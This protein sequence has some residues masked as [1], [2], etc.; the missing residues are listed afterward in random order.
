MSHASKLNNWY[1]NPKL[2]EK[3]RNLRKNATKA[4]VYLWKFGLKSKVMGYS[5][6]R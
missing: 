5:F 2:T 4:E 6:Q 3:A 1:H